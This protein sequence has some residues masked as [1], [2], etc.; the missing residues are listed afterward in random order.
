MSHAGH[1]V[2]DLAFG[3]IILCGGLDGDEGRGQRQARDNKRKDTLF[4]KRFFWGRNA[5]IVYRSTL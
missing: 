3:Q 2:T 1:D 4:H 5:Q